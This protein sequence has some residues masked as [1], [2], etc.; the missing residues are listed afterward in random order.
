MSTGISIDSSMF[1]DH[2]R[3]KDKAKTSLAKVLRL[4]AEYFIST[5]VEYEVEVG[6]TESYRELWNDLL[7]SMTVVPF[8]SSMVVAACDIKHQL[9]TQGIQIELA[10]LFIAATAMEKGLPLATLNH[11]HFKQIEGLKLFYPEQDQP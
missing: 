9:K 8:D 10:D 4:Y 5:V 6:M 3:A 11:R 7:E 2:M 1:I